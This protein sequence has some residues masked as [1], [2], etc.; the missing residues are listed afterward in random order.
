MHDIRHFSISLAEEI[1]RHLGKG[2]S[3]LSR[4]EEVQDW[5]S[6]FSSDFGGRGRP[7]AVQVSTSAASSSKRREET[8]VAH[9]SKRVGKVSR[10][11]SFSDGSGR[12]C[13]FASWCSSYSSLSLSLSLNLQCVLVN[14]EDKKMKDDRS[15]G[16]YDIWMDRV[17][18]IVSVRNCEKKRRRG[19]RTINFQLNH[20]QE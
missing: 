2:R 16:W 12:I 1:W 8:H 11:V 13:K 18:G 4:G 5:R 14:L 10:P 19:R 6:C 9:D 17:S 15:N 7:Q 3:R 20:S